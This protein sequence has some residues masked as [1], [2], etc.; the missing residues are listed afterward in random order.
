M[1]SPVNNLEALLDLKKKKRKKIKIQGFENTISQFIQISNI[2]IEIECTKPL[3]Y[4]D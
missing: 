3:G 2:M 4:H 1:N